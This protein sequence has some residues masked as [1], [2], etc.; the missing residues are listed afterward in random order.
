M[1]AFVQNQP[2]LA[3][4]QQLVVGYEELWIKDALVD[5]AR[6]IDFGDMHL[7]GSVVDGFVQW[8]RQ[9]CSLRAL[10]LRE[11][12]NYLSA[13]LVRVGLHDMACVLDLQAPAVS[14]DLADIA[15]QSEGGPIF[16]FAILAQKVQKM[17]ADG[18]HK[19][20]FVGQHEAVKLVL[21][22]KRWTRECQ[23]IYEEL[24]WLLQDKIASGRSA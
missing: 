6:K 8:L 16:F 13:A 2:A 5:A 7:L 15:F 9:E 10:S 17:Q 20:V 18:V 14:M 24:E 23:Q 4:G 22:S 1:I 19:L 21:G 3:I 12:S 11:L